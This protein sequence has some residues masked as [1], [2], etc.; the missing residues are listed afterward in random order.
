METIFE[1]NNLEFDPND[2]CLDA[3]SDISSSDDETINPDYVRDYIHSKSKASFKF[4]DIK[5]IIYGGQSSRFYLFRKTMNSKNTLIL[6]NKKSVPFYCWECITIQLEHRDIDIII[7][8]E[9]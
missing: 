8:K 3:V 9:S 6:N 7:R 4:K 5:S 1:E 2:P